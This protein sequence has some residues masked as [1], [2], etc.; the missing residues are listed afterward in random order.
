IF[1]FMGV[2][3]F[4][5]FTHIILLIRYKKHLFTD[6]G[7]LTFTLP[8]KKTTIIDSKL[9]VAF[10]FTVISYLVTFIDMLIINTISENFFLEYFG[11]SNYS[12]RMN[13][14]GNY[15]VPYIITYV[16]ITCVAI[17][18]YIA[19]M[20]V[21]VTVSALIAKKHKRLV[22]IGIF[23]L[24]T[25][26]VSYVVSSLTIYISFGAY[27]YSEEYLSLFTVETELVMLLGLLG[28]LIAVFGILYF[29][30]TLILNKKLNLA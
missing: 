13:Y 15:A 2:L 10:I 4:S 1:C 29:I 17:L 5:L 18:C 28:I 6:E 16:L 21:C 27:D 14:F 11:T 25:W 23:A 26:F 7:Y 19:L 8:V 24:F 20:Y 9:V 30:L 22:G 3:L 12:E